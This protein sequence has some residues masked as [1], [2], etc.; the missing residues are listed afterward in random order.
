MVTS[1]ATGKTRS[2]VQFLKKSDYTRIFC[3]VHEHRQLIEKK[4]NEQ[5]ARKFGK[6]I[7]I[8]NLAHSQHKASQVM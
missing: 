3:T 1:F 8:Y 7:I 5:R 6:E 2:G 4:V